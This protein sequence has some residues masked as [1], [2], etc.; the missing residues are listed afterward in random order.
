MD[1]VH[2]HSMETRLHLRRSQTSEQPRLAGALKDVLG[3]GLVEA[4]LERLGVP[5][6]EEIC[7]REIHTPVN[8][9]LSAA[10]AELAVDWS[11][12]LAESVARAVH[13]GGPRVVRY[14]TP[15][16]A[17]V[18]FALGVA[19]RDFGRAWAWRQMGLTDGDGGSA[20]YQLL[21]A[22]KREPGA[23]VPVLSA[24]AS[25]GALPALFAQLS[26]DAVPRLAS[27]ALEAAGAAVSWSDIEFACPAP[28]GGSA[29]PEPGR[30]A[31]AL[32]CSVIARATRPASSQRHVSRAVTVLALLETDRGLFYRSRAEV[33]RLVATAANA[34]LT[35]DVPS[36]DSA[37]PAAVQ[38]PPNLPMES[39][40]ET[41]NDSSVVASVITPRGEEPSTDG[42]APP[43]VDSAGGRDGV[44]RTPPRE[45]ERASAV[46][47]PG[48]TSAD[49]H[50][51]RGFTQA[52]GLLFLLGALAN[53][54][55]HRDMMAGEMGA[56]RTLAWM[57]HQ[58]SLTLADVE[59]RDPAA[60]AFAGLG[61]ER[62]P[63]SGG[64]AP[65]TPVEME[66]LLAWRQLLEEHL[67]T[68]LPGHRNLFAW[69]CR[70]PAE[71][72]ADPGWIEVHLPLEEVSTEIRGAGLD[73]DPGYLNWLGVVF[74]FM[75]GQPS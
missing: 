31:R 54:N 55:L 65:P 16:H 21:I 64:E 51:E 70:R 5:L 49:M 8:L 60:L 33:Q 66:Q 6:H 52:G 15:V 28:D 74:K 75:Y 61:P 11:L 2:I 34:F 19:T 18:D 62:D 4:A 24:V 72:V 32:G 48:E 39:F 3:E 68:R 37:E 36:M 22:L 13:R 43:R 38:S 29:S 23:I 67:V 17:L 53:L 7:I 73:L 69:V 40:D 46:T 71:I 56:R 1:T 35:G 14:P 59:E 58:L 10:S 27:H 44:D 9:R 30:I 63:P 41:L 57:L 45:L 42:N 25:N 47:E 26:A 20:P 50:R 12:A